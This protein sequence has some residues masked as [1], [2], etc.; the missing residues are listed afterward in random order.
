MYCE[1]DSL[2]SL[3]T[4]LHELTATLESTLAQNDH[5][6]PSLGVD[7]PSDYPF[8]D[9]DHA[10][11]AQM[12]YD[13]VDKAR[14]VASLALG[15]RES[16]LHLAFSFQDYFCLAVIQRYSLAKMVP[17]NTSVEYSNIAEVASLSERQVR[18]VMQH[19]IANGIFCEP[20]AGYVTHNALSKLLLEPGLDSLVGHFV[21]EAWTAQPSI[22]EAWKRFPS[23][24]EPRE[25]GFA[26]S[27]GDGKSLFDYFASHEASR[28]RFSLAMSALTTGGG[29]SP[30]FVVENY[31][32]SELPEGAIIVDVGGADGTLAVA[33]ANQFH[34]LNFIVQDLPGV[35]HTNTAALPANLQSRVTLQDHDFFAPQ[36]VQADVY[37]LRH[38][39]H[40]WPDKYCIIILR[41]L[42]A[43][44]KPSSRIVVC[45][46]VM[47]EPAE[48]SA[49]Q[50][51][52]RS[53]MNLQM[54]TMFNAKER[55]LHEWKSLLEQ[56]DR[57][58]H[59]KS[60]ITP[61]G[62]QDS[63]LEIALLQ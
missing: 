57:R 44:M 15:P 61:V 34:H 53:A 10:N 33:L 25:T 7:G 47:V 58:L 6:R 56:A 39:L 63:I 49:E 16:M 21:D 1:K 40:D 2:H 23:A 18:S 62:S 5:P 35:V 30:N 31:E 37:I 54:L 4:E 55:T 60:V 41:H 12:R 19:A 26:L 32:W 11:F 51:W 46:T 36:R 50:F 59:I 38:I 14:K 42:I 22:L 28:D 43:A 3:A 20:A 27:V 52:M 13:I 24:S 17:L 29:L 48:T 45:D 8:M 9:S